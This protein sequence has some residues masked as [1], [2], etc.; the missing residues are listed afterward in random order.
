MAALSRCLPVLASLAALASA[1][2]ARDGYVGSKV[3]YGCHTAIYRS[4]EKTGMGRSMTMA[5]EWKPDTLPSEATLVRP[6]SPRT[7]AVSHNQSGWHQSESEPGVFTVQHQLK[8]S[9]GSGVNGVTFLIQR[10][11]YLF[12]APLS[13][14]AKTRQWDFSPG[15][16][17]VDLG[18]NRVVPEE[19][20]NCHAGR[21]LPLEKKPGAYADP[22]FQELAIGCENCHGPGERHVK[23][24]GKQAGSIVNPAKLTPRLA[25]NIC[26]NCHQGGDARLLQPG[27]TYRDFHPGDWLFDTAVILKQPAQT[28][29][30]READLLQHSSAMQASR[31][32]RESSD[33]LGCMTCHDPHVQPEQAEAA[34]YYRARCLTCHSEQSCRFPL[35]AR[36]EQ[37][38]PDDCAGCHMAKRKVTQISHSALTNHRITAREGEPLPPVAEKQIDGLVLVNPPPG[39][40]IQ[41]SKVLLLR[42]YQELSPRNSAYQQRYLGLLDEL[43][44]AQPQDSFVQAAL[45]HKAFAEDKLDEAVAHFT[46]ALP[47]GDAAI[48]LEMGQALAKLGRSKEALEYLT[49]GVE[50]DPYNA[51]MQK[52][53]ILQYINLKSYP[54]ARQ[55]MQQYVDTFPED[56]FMRSLLVR[57]SK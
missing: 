53:L 23:S 10:G 49:K 28:S 24:L 1:Q 51:V 39:R 34:A 8:Y 54:E 33:K 41:L 38:P 16:E 11:A 3:C 50:T 47:L 19:C 4:F 2:P 27:K 37:K 22:P 29:E 56:S 18:F 40:S 57:V 25:E 26:L 21:P 48:Y 42:A 36:V 35:K 20:I 12:Q 44:K 17:Q 13:Y 31:C 5:S 14:Y 52:T 55:R 46:L 7:F 9:V 32:F 43:S 15:Y 30:Q 6:G 45:G